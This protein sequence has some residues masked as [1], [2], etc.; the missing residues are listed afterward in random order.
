M[1]EIQA[2]ACVSFAVG[3]FVGWCIGVIMSSWR[4]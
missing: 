1:S 2:A 4:K 3:A